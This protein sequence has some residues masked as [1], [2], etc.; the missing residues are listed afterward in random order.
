MLEVQQLE[1]QIKPLNPKVEGVVHM[2]FA[3]IKLINLISFFH[4]NNVGQIPLT[5]TFKWLGRHMLQV[6]E[7]EVC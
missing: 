6:R 2:C 5:R 4:T 1:R 7:S 3:G